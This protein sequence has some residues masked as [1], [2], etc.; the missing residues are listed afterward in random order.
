MKHKYLK[1]VATLRLSAEKCIGCGKC[2]EVCPHG[3]FSMNEKKAK[4]ED[5]DRCMECGACAKNCLVK[6][7]NVDAGV[8][9]ASAVIMGWI[10]GSEPSCDCSS[11]GECC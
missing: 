8:G 11:G 6:A 7:I 5:K 1:N 10:T 2:V 4:I 3:V 9:C